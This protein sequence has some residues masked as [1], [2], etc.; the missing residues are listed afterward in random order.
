MNAECF[1]SVTLKESKMSSTDEDKKF[2]SHAVAFVIGHTRNGSMVPLCASIA[3]MLKLENESLKQQVTKLQSQLHSQASKGFNCDLDSDL[4][5][6]FNLLLQFK[7]NRKKHKHKSYKALKGCLC[8]SCEKSLDESAIR[9]PLKKGDKVVISG[10]IS[11]T[12]CYIG[13]V[14]KLSF[15]EIFVGLHLDEAV[16][17]CNGSI[18]EKIYFETPPGYGMFAPLWS[19]CCLIENEM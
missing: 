13:H 12:V 6:Q 19:I 11:G 5:K 3:T 1:E 9:P 2:V 14:D 17:D 7:S 10:E 4:Q 8:D 18:E 15:P 16:G